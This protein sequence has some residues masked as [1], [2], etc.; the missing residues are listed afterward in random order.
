MIIGIGSDLTDCRRIE[1]VIQRQGDRFIKRVFTPHERDRL[2]ARQNRVGSYAKLFAAKEAVAKA[3]GTGIAKGVS[4]QDIE[5]RREMGAAPE[6]VLYNAALL[7]FNSL[8]PANRVGHIHLSLTDEW[9]YAQAFVI[10]SA[11]NLI[12]RDL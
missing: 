2:E 9:P 6:V 8:L 7:H 11:G 3:L 4:W 12:M 10:L 1:A 5:I